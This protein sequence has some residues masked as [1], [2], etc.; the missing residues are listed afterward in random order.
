MMASRTRAYQKQIGQKCFPELPETKDEA[1]SVADLLQAD[2]SSSVL[3]QDQASRA[4]ILELNQQQKLKDYQYLLFATHAILPAQ[5]DDIRQ[6]AVVLSHTQ[7]AAENGYLTVADVYGL[8]LNARLVTLSTCHTGQGEAITGEGLRGLAQAFMYA[9]STVL[10]ATL[11][12]VH[13]ESLRQ[14][15]ET[16]FKQLRQ[17]Q[18]LAIAL[19]A[20][21]RALWQHPQYRHPYF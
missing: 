19:Q 15:N 18:P 12:E 2:K 6:S 17:G 3:L 21:K 4:K 14:L 7:T 13:S 20:A 10:A 5:T 16:L 1:N 8:Q 11:W 9:G